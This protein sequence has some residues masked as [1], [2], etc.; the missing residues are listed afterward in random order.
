[1]IPMPLRQAA[2]WM[3]GW[4]IN[5]PGDCVV[6]AVATDSRELP[7]GA[8]FFA[9]SGPRFDGHDFVAPALA[10]GASAAVVA[11]NRSGAFSERV[12]VVDDPLA[13]LG[14]LARAHRAAHPARVIAIT[15]SA[16]KT[17]TKAMLAHVLATWRPTRAATRSFN[18]AIGVPLTLLSCEPSDALLVVEIGTSAPGE[19]AALADLVQPDLGMVTCIGDAHLE[20]L[21]GRGGVVVEKMSLFDRVR[22]GGDAIIEW[23]AADQARARWGALPRTGELHW[24][25][26]GANPRADVT[27]TAQRTGLYESSARIAGLDVRVPVP[28]AHNLV[29]A[30]GVFA[31]CRR[32]GMEAEAI[33]AALATFEAPDMRMRVLDVD[34]VTV[35]AD[36]YN[37][38]PTS[39]AAAIATLAGVEGG[40][41]VLVVG[42][43]AELGDASAQFHRDVGRQAV[44]AG[45]DVV[46]SIG[47][48]ARA[49]TEAASVAGGGPRTWHFPDAAAA[50]AE[51]AR[52]TQPGDTVVVKGSR[53]A[54]LEAVYAPD[55]GEPA[56][57]T[58]VAR[59]D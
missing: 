43:M 19:I 49:V 27:V 57:Q 56:E 18:N 32:L 8:L 5:C 52:F 59:V 10:A 37:A 40:R 50:R 39:M 24:V 58:A 2:D 26:Y 22:S 44:D 23:E 53:V 36:C 41:R 11:K 42:E 48:A 4:L 46:V 3:Q 30:A 17:T 31:V 21:G 13:A 25:T 45:A 38:N 28:G 7:R 9:L 54:G 16:G 51:W 47:L 20:G 55:A 1:M 12:I 33:I 15:G 29:N 14:R 6:R 35:I 34:G